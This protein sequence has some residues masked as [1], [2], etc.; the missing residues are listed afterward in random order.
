MASKPIR[1]GARRGA[2]FGT[3]AAWTLLSV[4]IISC[5]SGNKATDSDDDDDAVEIPRVAVIYADSV[6]AGADTLFTDSGLVYIELEAGTGKRAVRGS[7]VSVHYTG[8]LQDGTVF[9]SSYPRGAA[10]RFSV[11]AGTVI[12][13]WDEGLALMAEGGRAR[14]IIPS[15]LA[16]GARGAGNVIPPNATILFDLWLAD[17]D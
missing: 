8:L 13:G 3:M 16:Y 4:C 5:G 1:P 2:R 15:G 17:V 12:A 14:L 11:G 9:D 10:F 6:L 7:F